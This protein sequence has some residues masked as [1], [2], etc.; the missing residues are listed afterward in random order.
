M[1]F[2]GI[3][4]QLIIRTSAIIAMIA[5]CMMLIS[6][7]IM[8]KQMVSDA[9]TILDVI[10][11]Q[12]SKEISS[13]IKEN[14]IK[15]SAVAEMPDII[16][17]GAPWEM[18]KQILSTKREANKFKGL[19]IV[20]KDGNLKDS[21]GVAI[22][23]KEK[24]YFK[25]TMKGR[26]YASDIFVSS[27]DGKLEITYCAPI[28]DSDKLVKG[29][30]VASID[31]TDISKILEG[32]NYGDTGQCFLINKSGKLIGHKDSSML[33]AEKTFIDLASDDKEKEEL[34][35]IQKDVISSQV[36]M[37]EYKDSK[38]NKYIAYSPV[39]GQNWIFGMTI[40][41]EGDILKGLKKINLMNTMAG[42]IAIVIGIILSFIS[43]SGI[44]KRLKTLR[45]NIK[46][47]ST[48]DFSKPM[49][50]EHM[51]SKDEIG[52][53]YNATEELRKD[54]GYTLGQ[55]KNN[56][57]IIADESSNL[58]A[59]SEEFVASTE[60]ISVAMEEAATGN[61]TQSQELLTMNQ[62]F[63]DFGN[64]IEAMG[65]NIEDIFKASNVI[66]DKSQSSDKDMNT[67]R[68]S[69]ENFNDNFQEFM[70][71]I[72]SM[73]QKIKTVNEITT[74]INSIAEQTNLLA[75]NA[76]IEAAR[77]GEQGKGFAVVA[78]E[79]RKLAEQSKNSSQGI[80]EVVASVLKESEKMVQG[81]GVMKEV[82]DEQKDSVAQSIVSFM[83][84]S[85][86]IDKII[87]KI[88]DISDQSDKIEKQKTEVMAK[89][90]NASAIS[91]EM[92]ATTEEVS[93]SSQQL[94]ASSEEVANS[95]TKLSQL[96]QDLNEV[97]GKFKI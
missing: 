8:E 33:G 45:E 29:M 47:V 76:A 31:A 36:D 43:A 19:A 74:V 75:L 32:I 78:D 88:A 3:K 92:A 40:E 70:N 84:I 41:K 94:N 53:I 1:K 51:H 91:E 62:T 85:E 82:L 77:A 25:E 22:N 12:N 35:K 18:K 55:V 71:S 11:V 15:V 67:L 57:N 23:I 66:R 72:D 42:V 58:A 20:D 56:S 46:L 59:L 63:Y 95:S 96:T 61:T 28:L 7:N 34:G 14:L 27:T 5:I 50:K 80:Y 17:E 37:K 97:V 64:S 44:S 73:E 6:N 38:S 69:L 68:D 4:T 21:E 52:D 60:N 54:I 24:D 65:K 16:D 89:M 86:E 90:E 87:P 2:K 93:A 48:G 10:V 13:K 49:P 26:A 30:I 81:T 83:S 9:K 39:D 79:I